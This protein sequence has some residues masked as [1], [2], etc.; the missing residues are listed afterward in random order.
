MNGAFVPAGSYSKTCNNIVVTLHAKA[1][2]IDGSWVPAALNITELQSAD[3][4]NIDGVLRNVGLG[5]IPAGFVP[6][7]SYTKTCQDIQVVLTCQAQKLDGS[8]VPTAFVLTDIARPGNLAN[9]DGKLVN[10]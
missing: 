9:I 10:E 4:E 2:K 3:I 1:Q 8:W 6:E 7:G 5:G